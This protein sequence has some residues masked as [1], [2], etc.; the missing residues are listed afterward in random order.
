MRIKHGKGT[1][2]GV[3]KRS[4]LLIAVL[5]VCAVFAVVALMGV[6]QDKGAKPAKKD[7]IP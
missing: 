1:E 5:C 3:M 7:F 2:D 6:A 4:T